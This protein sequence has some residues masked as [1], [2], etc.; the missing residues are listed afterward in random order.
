MSVDAERMYEL[1]LYGHLVWSAPL[2][3]VASVLLLWD[4]LGL[5]VFAGLGVLVLTFLLNI[6]MMR[7]NKQLQVQQRKTFFC[8]QFSQQNFFSSF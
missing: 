1:M 3:I 4:V 2:Q 8:Q 5:A 6:Y 7:R